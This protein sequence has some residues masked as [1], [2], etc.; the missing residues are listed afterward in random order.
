MDRPNVA[1]ENVLAAVLMAYAMLSVHGGSHRARGPSLARSCACLAGTE[2]VS[3]IMRH[4]VGVMDPGDY[5]RFGDLVQVARE[6]RELD[7]TALRESERLL[8]EM[9]SAAAVLAEHV[10]T[11]ISALPKRHL[12]SDD[13]GDDPMARIAEIWERSRR[14]AGL[15]GE[16][17][18]HAHRSQVALGHIGVQ[19]SKPTPDQ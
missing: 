13:S 15:F 3:S 10:Q 17:G 11:E 4:V 12:L 2:A 6:R 18:R 1:E 7:M 5:T 9:A 19:H 14:I 16:V 8:G